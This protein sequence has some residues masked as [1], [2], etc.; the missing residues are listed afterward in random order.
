MG[1]TMPV[2]LSDYLNRLPDERRKA[3]EA[4]A[5]VLIE[6]EATLREL[7]AAR[8]RSQEQIA[9]RLGIKQSAVSKLERRTDMYVSTLR[10]LI[11]A[12]GGELDIIARFP[13]H[14]PV[15]ITQFRSLKG[16]VLSRD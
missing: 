14:P 1:F 15:R 6:E 13:D 16:E 9:E 3:I 5:A 7:R 8:E 12:L 10:D 11:R 4:R 2:K